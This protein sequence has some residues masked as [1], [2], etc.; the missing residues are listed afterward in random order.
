MKT[1]KL[2]RL[3]NNQGCEFDKIES[4]SLKAIKE[5]AKKRSGDYLLDID[6]V[7]NIMNGFNESMQY[8][9]KNNRF[10]RVI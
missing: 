6:T 2:A 7:Y 1:L 9:V 5:W 10:Y 8:K 4:N 3:I